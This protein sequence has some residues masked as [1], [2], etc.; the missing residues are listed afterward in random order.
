MPDAIVMDKAD[1]FVDFGLPIISSS[2]S[3]NGEAD[4][5][6]GGSLDGQLVQIHFHVRPGI[7]PNDLMGENLQS[8][9]ALYDGIK[10]SLDGELGRNFVRMLAKCYGSSRTSFLMP[11]ELSFTA[12]AIDGDPAKLATELVKMK[13]FHETG[14]TDEEEGPAY[15]E[16]FFNADL[17]NGML[18]LNEKDMDFRAG[19]LNAFPPEPN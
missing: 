13:L 1:G 2:V 11:V 3:E 4:L 8:V 18:G 14:S 15:F 7:L 16:M 12:V 6:V 17:P 5:L 9:E 10:M 19:V